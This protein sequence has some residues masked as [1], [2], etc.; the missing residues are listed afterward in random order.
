MIWRIILLCLLGAPLAL[1]NLPRHATPADAV[2]VVSSWKAFGPDASGTYGGLQGVGGLEAVYQ[3]LTTTGIL[4]DYFGNVLGGIAGGQVSWTSNRFSS[5][6]PV[7]GYQSV[8]LSQSTTLAQATVWRGNRV[9][10]TGLIWIGARYYDPVAGHFLSP[11]PLGHTASLDL[12]SAFNG[13]PLNFFDPLGR[14]SQEVNHQFLNDPK[15]QMSL[16]GVDPQ[17]VARNQWYKSLPPSEQNTVNVPLPFLYTTVHMFNAMQSGDVAV[18]GEAGAALR[19]AGL[20]TV[21]FADLGEVLGGPRPVRA[22]ANAEILATSP[23]AAETATADGSFYSVAYEMK[24]NP[25][26]LGRSRPVQLNRANAALDTAIQADPQFATQME[27]L[28]PG[29]SDSVSR[30][31]GRETPSDWIWHHDQGAGIMQL[32]PEAQH[33]P[34]SIFWDTLHPG[35]AEAIQSGRSRQA[36]RQTNQLCAIFQNST[37]TKA[38]S[39]SSDARRRTKSSMRFNPTLASSCRKIILSYCDIQ[40]AGTRNLTRLSRLT[41]QELLGGR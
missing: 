7:P 5:Y 37:S 8:S 27:K 13:D 29:V 36:R 28:I 15:L 11:D 1:A 31:G 24:L 17:E 14:C 23:N 22:G 9:D 35:D 33:T 4:Q 18:I 3:G 26:D 6:G 21:L 39:A 34:G 10:E 40:T 12:Y 32:V 20:A 25:A 41:G 16:L 2:S 30:V 19:N 38:E